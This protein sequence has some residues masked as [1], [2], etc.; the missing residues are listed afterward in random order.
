[1][2]PRLVLAAAL[3]AA[4][5]SAPPAPAQS[6]PAPGCLLASRTFQSASAAI[7]TA[8]LVTSSIQAA[9]LRG[10]IADV[11]VQL[12]IQHPAPGELDVTLTSPD[13]R[14]VTLTTDNGPTSNGQVYLDGAVFDDQANP[15]GPLPY[16]QNVGLVTDHSYADFP[17]L[18]LYAAPEEPLSV[19]NGTQAEG[20]WLLR[21]DHDT[22][23]VSGTLVAWLLT[24]RT[25]P[26]GAHTVSQTL[27]NTTDLPI[28]SGAPSLVTSEIVVPPGAAPGVIDSLTVLTTLLHS[29]NADVDMA[30]RS[31]AGT[32]VTLT[33]DNGG[34]NGQ[35]FAG[36]AWQDWANGEAGALPYAFNNGL[37]TDHA[38]AHLVTADRLAP[39]EPL[40]AFRGED[41]T[42][43]WTLAVY[44]DT[45]GEGG[46]LL[47][48]GLAFD[49]LLECRGKGDFDGS[50]AEDLVLRRTS[51]NAHVLW[52]M[53]GAT[54][55]SEAPLVPQPGPGLQAVGADQFL[56]LD[57]E[58]PAVP[59]GSRPEEGGDERPASG[60]FN[61]DADLVFQNVATGQVEF[62]EM[63]GAQRVGD[64]VPLTGA[65]PLP[66]NWKLSATGDFN[67]DGSADLLWRNVTSQKIVIWTLGENGAPA[68]HKTGAIVPSPDHAVDANWEIV[69]ALDFDHDNNRDLL[70]YN[71]SSGKIVIWFLDQQAVRILG[72]FTDPPNAGDANWRVVAAGDYG[73]PAQGDQ[74][75]D[76]VWRNSTSGRLVIWHMNGSFESPARLSGTFTSPDRPDAPL[77]WTVVGPK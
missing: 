67:H 69:A 70:W 32:W 52:L 58:G 9:G 77:D 63:S 68:T 25:R 4:L 76:I 73:P 24:I 66:A 65:A 60:A 53:N 62:W 72:K 6:R 18:P 11:D 43:T 28:G 16:L 46:A 19:F 14:I 54:R 50:L 51:D 74:I 13:G 20:T 12:V 30:L 35:V 17:A 27:F 29:R 37:A 23:G 36:T 71:G 47:E 22:P 42:G 55:V 40:S 5:A 75:P 21:I 7:P 33:T 8:G 3:A 2:S 38:Y 61:T 39:E 64:P 48:W 44:D 34:L 59:I 57:H 56:G 15:G 49:T 10:V 45:T 1:M 41:P 26:A 31:P